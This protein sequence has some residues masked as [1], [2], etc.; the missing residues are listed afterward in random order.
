MGR[1]CDNCGGKGW[2]WTGQARE[3]CPG[4]L[5]NGYPRPREDWAQG[6]MP[7]VPDPSKNRDPEVIA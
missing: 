5:G 1:V 6:P 3:L 7:Q 2:R 4:C